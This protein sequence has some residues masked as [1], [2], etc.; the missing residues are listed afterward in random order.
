[1]PK[2]KA[3]ED[4]TE[5]EVEEEEKG[6]Q[7]GREG[8]LVF[9]IL[10]LFASFNDTFIVRSSAPPRCRPDENV[11]C[12]AQLHALRGRAAAGVGREE[13]GETEGLVRAHLTTTSAAAA[14]A[15]GIVGCCCLAIAA[16]HG[17][18]RTRDGLPVH[19]RYEGEG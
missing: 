10:R 6:P 8:E 18:L 13:G 3:E 19:R 5:I 9:G 11:P 7:L 4:V 17:R 16:H 2:A 12:P 15:H 14:A 1:M